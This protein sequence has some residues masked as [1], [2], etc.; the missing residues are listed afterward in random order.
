[1]ILHNFEEEPHTEF[2]FADIVSKSH[3]SSVAG[4]AKVR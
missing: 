2:T 3:G 1:M 4:L